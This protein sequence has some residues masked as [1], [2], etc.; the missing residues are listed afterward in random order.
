[1]FDNTSLF[2][3]HLYARSNSE[4]IIFNSAAVE[5]FLVLHSFGVPA[6]RYRSLSGPPIA[7][8]ISPERKEFHFFKPQFICQPSLLAGMLEIKKEN[9]DDSDIYFEN[10]DPEDFVI[11]A[12]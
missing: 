9:V 6:K 12:E 4:R 11:F 2:P 7:F 5:G 3:A 1:M 10:E 8:R